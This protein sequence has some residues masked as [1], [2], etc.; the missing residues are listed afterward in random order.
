LLAA[1]SERQTLASYLTKVLSPRLR[2]LL[3]PGKGYQTV[4]DTMLAPS[5]AKDCVIDMLCNN[6]VSV[7]HVR[8]WCCGCVP[9]PVACCA[10]GVGFI[11]F[12]ARSRCLPPPSLL[13]RMWPLPLRTWWW[14]CLTC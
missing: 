4:L 5:A 1:G 12:L 13:G 11:C 2:S 8:C 10:C 7:E 3:D 6:V 9:Y 14:G